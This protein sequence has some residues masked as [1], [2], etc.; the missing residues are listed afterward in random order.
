MHPRRTS[1]PDLLFSVT[2]LGLSLPGREEQDSGD[3]AAA[4]TSWC[5][6]FGPVFTPPVK[7]GQDPFETESLPEDLGYHIQMKDGVIYI[8]EDK[9]AAGRNEPK[10]LSYPSLEN[11]INDMNFLLALTAQGPV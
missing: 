2:V 1:C 3:L 6:P 8:Y 11:F 4:C 10:D 5:S 9:A 7:D